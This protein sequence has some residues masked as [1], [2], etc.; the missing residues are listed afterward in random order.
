MNALAYLSI[1]T[2]ASVVAS[3]DITT[4]YNMV[5]YYQENIDKYEFMKDVK[6]ITYIF[7]NSPKS[8]LIVN[9]IKETATDERFRSMKQVEPDELKRTYIQS[10]NSNSE[11]Q[12]TLTEQDY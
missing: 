7:E 2:E 8:D 11:F 9:R 4:L 3:K 10:M 5:K 1:D 12:Y 6:N